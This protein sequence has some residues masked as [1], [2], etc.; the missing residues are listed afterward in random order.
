M[1]IEI[2]THFGG[3]REVDEEIAKKLVNNLMNGITAI[4]ENKKAAYIEEHHLRGV[5]V[6]ELLNDKI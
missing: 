3:W 1:A 6:E 5:T 4:P 2:K